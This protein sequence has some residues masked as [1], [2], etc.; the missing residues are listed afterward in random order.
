MHSV[1]VCDKQIEEALKIAIITHVNPDADTLCSAVGLKEIIKTNYQKEKQIDIY[2]DVVID[3]NSVYYPITKNEVLN[4]SDSEIYDL[5]IAVDCLDID[6]MGNNKFIF[7]NAKSTLNIDHHISNNAFAENNLV[8]KCSSTCELLYYLFTQVGK[9]IPDCVCKLFYAGVITD[10]N[11]L[12]NGEVSTYTYNLIQEFLDRGINLDAVREHFMKSNT[13]SK[14][15]LLERALFSLKLIDFNQLAFMKLSKNDFKICQAT[16]DDT[17]GIINHAIGIQGVA[18]AVLKIEHEDDKIE[19]KLRGKSGVNVAQIAEKFGG[20]GHADMA[21][22]FCNG[23]WLQ[24]K[25]E[26]FSAC[27][28]Q[29]ACLGQSAAQNLFFDDDFEQNT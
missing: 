2:V 18:I 10:T 16:L 29:I 27:H 12:T 11:N 7:E 14:T 26:L 28:E 13:L 15:H 3:E 9:K 20:G 19:I 25:S 23:D 6:R 8:F 24:I 21:G 17:Q 1:R 5:A 22:F 4:R